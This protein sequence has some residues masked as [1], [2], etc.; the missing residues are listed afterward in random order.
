MVFHHYE[1]GHAHPQKKSICILVE[2][3]S[4]GSLLALKK[5]ALGARRLGRAVCFR[6]SAPIFFRL[7]SEDNYKAPHLNSK[8]IFLYYKIFMI[9]LLINY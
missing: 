1:R 9:N 7:A 8:F 2:T 3:N 4:P 5:W 6:R